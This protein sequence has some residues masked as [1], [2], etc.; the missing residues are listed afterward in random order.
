MRLTREDYIK[1]WRD[2]FIV[3]M[4]KAMELEDAGDPAGARRYR[5][6]AKTYLK[7][8]NDQKSILDRS[9]NSDPPTDQVILSESTTPQSE[10]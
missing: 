1:C 6:Y 9:F 2:R 10:G 5:D 7:Y 4:T 3:N 8:L